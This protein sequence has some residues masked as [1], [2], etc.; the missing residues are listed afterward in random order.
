VGHRNHDRISQ[1]DGLIILQDAGLFVIDPS[2]QETR[3]TDQFGNQF[4]HVTPNQTRRDGAEY[5][6]SR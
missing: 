1:P 5:S 6:T 2:Y 4:R 3:R